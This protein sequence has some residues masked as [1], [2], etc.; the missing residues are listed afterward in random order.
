MSKTVTEKIFSV[1]CGKSLKNGDI[2]ICNVDLLMANDTTAPIAINSFKKMSGS[3]VKNPNNIIFIIDHASPSPNQ[4]VSNLHTMIRQFA[5]E[6][7]IKLYDVGEGVCHQIM[8]E[9]KYIKPGQL[10]I[11]ADSHT[12]TY[13]ALGALST[14]VG[15]TDLALAMLTGKL[16]FKVPATIK[17]N[18]EG[19]FPHGVYA[20]DFILYL[21]G[22]IG[23]NGATY[24]SIEFYGKPLENM[25]LS[26]KL[27]IC[28]MVVEM[29]AKNGIICDNRTRLQ[30]DPGAK[31]E[32]I[33]KINLSDLE[34]YV[35]KPHSVDNVEKI[36]NIGNVAINQG[37]LGTCTNGRIEDLRIASKI[38]KGKHI[39]EGVRF[40]IAPASKG[41]FLKAIEEGL[42][43]ILIAAGGVFVT[44]GCAVCVGTH[45]G[46]PS[47]GDVVISTANRNFKGRMGNNKSFIYLASPATVAASVLKGKITD[48][49]KLR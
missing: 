1:H 25:T 12:C 39:S 41:I 13:G 45:L 14:G 6:Q 37:F 42:V 4:K 48:S 29:G 31:F 17:V 7:D 15:S 47:D 5:K 19:D 16:W 30:S 22:K 24:K 28:N 11:G 35:S 8:I 18:L 32:K 23:I 40:I 34:P 33:L 43:E 9:S 21:I 20:K 36:S 49:R 46:V 26:S 2:A 10:I 3:K 38:L 44:P 27:T